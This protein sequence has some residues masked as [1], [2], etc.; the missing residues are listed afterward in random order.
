MRLRL[1]RRRGFRLEEESRA[2][3]GR[4]AV[5]VA[6][7]TKWGNPWKPGTPGSFWLPDFP[8]ADAPVGVA[9]DAG[10]AVALYRR[11]LTGGPDAVARLL[12]ARLNR[13]GRAI[14]RDMLRWHASAIRTRL[15]GL[16]GRNLACWC[17][18]DAPCHADVLIE[19]AN[20]DGGAGPWIGKGSDDG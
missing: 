5:V 2:V 18:P 7:P 17:A 20:G 8:I 3:N 15:P 9:L 1:Q 12:P 11:L 16:H 13:T 6:R 10:D 14:V 4:T 19:L